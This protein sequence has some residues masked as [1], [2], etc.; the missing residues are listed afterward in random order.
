MRCWLAL[1][2]ATIICG[3][4]PALGQSR[5]DDAGRVLADRQ[6]AVEE[7]WR[8]LAEP[9]LPLIEPH[10][11]DAA[12]A[13][14]TFAY[15]GDPTITGVRLDSVINAPEAAPIVTDYSRDFTLPL[16]RLSDSMIWTLTVDVP[17]DVQ[18]SY[19]FLVE[20]DIG[21]HRR[22]D[23]ANR[24][25]LR[26][27]DGANLLVLDQVGNPSAWWPV[28][29]RQA[30]PLTGMALQSEALD[31]TVLLQAFLAPDAEADAPVLIVY[32]AFLWGVR[33]PAWEI[34]HNLSRDG[35]IPSTHVV[36]IDQL[37]RES[38]RTAYADQAAFVADELLPFLREEAGIAVPAAEIVVAGAS[39][40]GL[41]AVISALERPDAV[42]AAL[43]LS[44]SFYWAPDGE[45]PEWLLRQLTPSL[46]PTARFYIAAGSLEYVR[47]STN[48][49]HVML[50][51]N[52][53]FARALSDAGYQ[54][55]LDVFAGGHDVAA[56]RAA[57]AEGLVALLGEADE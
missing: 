15:R 5:L 3:S 14:V 47:T 43:S 41:S 8:V 11:H 7:A 19:S 38:A 52:R 6:W 56:W 49:G 54:A 10:P 34:V 20:S 37:D 26:G 28:P 13:R 17:R 27:L 33:A 29:E 40:R 39:R 35:L 50:D 51:T 36:L 21:V 23:T 2:L 45:R 55:E 48:R 53:R 44:G 31:R 12:L 22:T 16:R 18:A 57:L 4:G 25:R 46:T 42:T 1:C 30:R 9:G 24:R 32:D